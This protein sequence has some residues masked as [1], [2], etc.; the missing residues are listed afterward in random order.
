MSIMIA[1]EKKGRAC[2]HF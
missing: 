1:M 2:I